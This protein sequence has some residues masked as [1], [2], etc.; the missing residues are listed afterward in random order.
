MACNFAMAQIVD[1]STKQWYWNVK[2]SLDKNTP[3]G[4][5][6]FQQKKI[7]KHPNEYENETTMDGK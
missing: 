4:D 1:Y 6:Q 2:A 7:N 3:L 5:L